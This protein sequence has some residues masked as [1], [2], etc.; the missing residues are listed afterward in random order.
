MATVET[1]AD[2]DS[3]TVSRN[4]NAVRIRINA[5]DA[6]ELHQEF[7][8]ESRENLV[9]LIGGSRVLIAPVDRDRY[10]RIV[11]DVFVD[12]KNIG[13]SQIY[14]GFAWYFRVKSMRRDGYQAAEEQARGQ[15]RGLW[16]SSQP[17]P[18][19]EWRK[20]HQRNDESK[21]GKL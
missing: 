20:E 6:P 21:A 18:P 12:E 1:F 5:I 15:N 9:K 17:Q 16:H 2:G 11:A 13:L 3:F 10:G 8:P 14:D 7:G 19:W 4:G